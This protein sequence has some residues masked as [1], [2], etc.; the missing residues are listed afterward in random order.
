M[1]FNTIDFAIFLPIIFGI[2]WLIPSAYLKVQNLLI[3]LASY[4][5]YAY[6]D[7]RFLFLLIFST[8]LDFYSGIK[9]S[10]SEKKEIKKFWFWLSIS[11]N[12]GF[13]A[14]FKYFNFFAA[15]F[16]DVGAGLGIVLHPFVLNI[17]LPVG[18]SFYTFHGVSY[19]IDV[20]KDKIPVEKDFVNYAVFV[21]FFPLL[22]A[23][24]IERAR[25]LLPQIKAK[26][27]F[28]YP[29][30]VEGMELILWGLFKKVVIADQC[31]EYVDIIF[32][33]PQSFTG[34][35][36]GISLVLFAFQVYGD[37]SGYSDIALGTAK[38]FGFSLVRNFNFPL[39]ST[40][41][42]ELW[43]KWHISLFTW[44]RDYVY[45]PLGGG[46]GDK[47]KRYRNLAILFILSGFWHGANWTYLVWGT[48]NALIVI[49]YIHF[50]L[51]WKE[52]ES[53][54]SISYF[55]R[56]TIAIMLTF[57]LFCSGMVF[58]RAKNLTQSWLL[59]SKIFSSSIFAY[60]HIGQ[61]IGQLKQ[62]FGALSILVLLVVLAVFMFIEW[63]GRNTPTI[64][65]GLH[66]K[67]RTLRWAIYY[68]VFF[69]VV[70]FGYVKKAYI[71]F[72]F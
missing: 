58:F 5:F 12:L 17:V 33:Q 7:W 60:P 66:N 63:Q 69:M 42:P 54:K 9:I 67:N 49:V 10:Q 26:R 35:A 51:E 40:S 19:V 61:T 21:S 34:S 23:G 1:L 6:W 24:P 46:K 22:V 44:F 37:F 8:L 27:M 16:V 41:M 72:Q 18:I 43:R 14:V 29:K 68:L 31:A 64:F 59:V 11:I 45:A 50:N 3:L 39:F 13:L 2:Y 32:K 71:Y 20:Y 38:L 70:Y 30:A 62:P 15:S 25:H 53:E 56:R 65:S 36:I 4:F 28:S 57:S 47:M 52:K 55:S 48:Y